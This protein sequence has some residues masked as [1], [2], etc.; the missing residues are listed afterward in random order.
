M[1]RRLFGRRVSAS[2][3]RRVT[4]AVCALSFASDEA[5]APGRFMPARAGLIFE[6]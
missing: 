3:A 4:T 2:C 5:F 6:F 1:A